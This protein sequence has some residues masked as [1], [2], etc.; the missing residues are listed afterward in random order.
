[1]DYDLTVI[2]FDTAD[3]LT[4]DETIIG[5]LRAVLEENDT[6]LLLSALDDIE[7]AKS[8]RSCEG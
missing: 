6:D 5:Y 4:D 2:P 3:F 7:K 1:M 8:M